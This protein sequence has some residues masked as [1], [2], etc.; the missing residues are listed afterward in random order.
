MN[1]K[2]YFPVREYYKK[3]IVP[4][5]PGKFKTVKDKMVCPLHNDHDPSL[6]TVNSKAEGEICHCFGCNFWGNIIELHQKVNRKY[7]KKYLT[8]DEAKHDLCRIFDIKYESLPIE[9]T[10]KVL[11]KDIRQEMEMARALERFDIGDFQQMIIEGKRNKS[12]I[13]Y[14]NTLIMSM[15]NEVKQ[16]GEEDTD[17]KEEQ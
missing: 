17:G 1:Y 5:D 15:L 14:F 9:E 6:G 8:D 2:K 7:Y 12:G 3:Y 16:S 13:A 11:D 4:I 10:S